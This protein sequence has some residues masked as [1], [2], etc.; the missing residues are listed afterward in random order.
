MADHFPEDIPGHGG[1]MYG[2]PPDLPG[3]SPFDGRPCTENLFRRILAA[4]S[5]SSP[6]SPSSAFR[7]AGFGCPID[8]DVWEKQNRVPL[9]PGM[10][11]HWI[12]A[13]TL[14]DRPDPVD[15]QN[16]LV[17]VMNKWFGESPIDPA[18]SLPFDPSLSR[19]GSSD[20]II[21]KSAG[22]SQPVL[23][24]A[25]KRREQLTDV[26]TVN[27]EGGVIFLE[28]S[29]NYRGFNKDAPWPVHTAPGMFG[30]LKT[31]TRC[32]FD[33][34]WMLVE[35]AKTEEVAQP[36]KEILVGDL[37]KAGAKKVA[38]TV[39]APIEDTVIWAIGITLALAGTVYVA[40]K[41]ARV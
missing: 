4:R 30:G 14:R 29:F 20:A 23:A 8:P 17:A 16:T 35:V 18:I 3:S 39:K 33:A 24:N 19:A 25:I 6:S 32:P 40:R 21:I 28:I 1:L 26:P 22:A 11:N 41:V 38:D 36:K 37:I 31:R 5:S 13:R 9:F 10:V 2:A 27:G 12:L 34:D 7:V 15:L